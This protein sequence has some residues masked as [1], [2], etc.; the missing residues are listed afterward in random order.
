MKPTHHK[1]TLETDA[2]VFSLFLNV[3]KLKKTT[4]KPTIGS[5]PIL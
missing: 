3:G 1:P 2:S 4:L 5:P